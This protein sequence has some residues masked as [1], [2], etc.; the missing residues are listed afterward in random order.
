VQGY[1][2]WKP[3]PLFVSSTFQDMQSERHYL[4]SVVFL[5]L[6]EKLRKLCHFL[7][8]IDLRMGIG[9][10]EIPEKDLLVLRVCVDEI[11]RSRP[12]FIGILGDRYGWVPP[13]EIAQAVAAEAGY[14]QSVA[15]MSVT[16]LEIELGALADPAQRKFSRFYF[17][18]PLPY[19]KMP[20]EIAARYSDGY[21][22]DP[23]ADKRRRNLAELKCRIGKLMGDRVRSYTAAWDESAGCVTDLQKWGAQVEKDLW[24]DL[25]S[26]TLSGAPPQPTTWQEREDRILEEFVAGHCREFK[27]CEEPLQELLRFASAR[28]PEDPWLAFVTGEGGSGKSSL[29]GETVRSLKSDTNVLVLAHA[30]GISAHSSRLETMLGR[31]SATLSQAVAAPQDAAI[32]A[33]YGVDQRF[34]ALLAR[35]AR[36]RRVVCLIDGLNRFEQ[37]DAVRYLHWLPRNW[38]A[39]ARLI[40][41]TTPGSNVDAL[42]G[43]LGAKVLNLG[44]LSASDARQVIE[45]SCQRHHAVLSE[46]VKAALA[47]G[48]GYAG[49]PSGRSPLWLHLAL[50]RLL[51]LDTSDLAEAQRRYTG[52]A[53]R[54]LQ[55]FRYDL[56]RSFPGTADGLYERL[57]AWM[58][59]TY[60]EGWLGGIGKLLAVSRHGLRDADLRATL[61]ALTGCAWSEL[62]FANLRR[63]FRGE[64]VQRGPFGQWDFLHSQARL[65]IERRWLGDRAGLRDLHRLV[66]RHL[67]GLPEKDVLR[68]SELMYHLIRADLPDGAAEYCAGIDPGSEVEVRAAT[69][70]LATEIGQW[71]GTWPNPG[72]QWVASLP[73]RAAEPMAAQAICAL[74]L[75]R[76]VDSLAE[77]SPDTRLA[78][79]AAVCGALKKVCEERTLATIAQRELAVG[80]NRWGELLDERGSGEEALGKYQDALR[81]REALWQAAPHSREAAR[82]VSVSLDRLMGQAMKAGRLELAEELCRRDLAISLTLYERFPGDE[83]LR[84][85]FV[86]CLRAGD[87]LARMERHD[88]ALA[89]YGQA[90]EAASHLAHRDVESDARARDLAAVQERLGDLR[91]RTGDHAGAEELFAAALAI[92]ENLHRKNPESHEDAR[93]LMALCGLAAELHLGRYLQFLYRAYEISG[94]LYRKRPGRPEPARD[95]L[96]SS[97]RLAAMYRALGQE[98]QA[99]ELNS[100][101]RDLIRDLPREVVESDPDLVEIMKHIR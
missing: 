12:F 40:V 27:G 44:G 41:T 39:N 87:L 2:I 51:I 22:D 9:V 70:A 73:G 35:V 67:K 49:A 94:S 62:E 13:A 82:D 76:L 20:R 69:Q 63:G 23:D 96:I 72:L 5:A 34:A 29:F 92:R 65:S 48:D 19:R 1:A 53:E 79:V 100:E 66:V 37:S 11:R 18:E 59:G 21:C 93:N 71:E 64:L 58:A 61:P 26:A 4:G 33:G 46:E 91:N 25:E 54:R 90:L 84:D 24:E 97:F 43:P 99:G 56:L 47:S 15:G 28:N 85:R 83:T 52:D 57:L 75:D 89:A 32:P 50:A 7:E 80:L 95:H 101:C 8:P 14:R 81:F 55:S 78:L 42:A 10:A 60:G 88:R 38:P 45:A 31:W 98:Q 68:Q 17:R 74:F 86:S 6:E 3:R 30:A 16:A 77:C 36:G